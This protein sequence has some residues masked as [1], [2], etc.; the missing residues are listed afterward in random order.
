MKFKIKK[1]YLLESLNDVS[2]AM[3]SK[4][5]IP[6]LAGVKFEVKKDGI[7]LTCSDDDITIQSFIDKKKIETIDDDG[8]VVIPGK[9]ILDIVRKIPNEFIEIETDGL[10]IVIS[11]P[12]SVY[13]L[14]GMDA[15]DYPDK[16]LELTKSPIII[17]KKVIKN[18]INQTSFAISTQESRPI[19]TGINISIKENKLDAI[20]TDSYRLS[21]KIVI[22]KNAIDNEVNIVVPGRNLIELNKILNE[23]DEDIE[24]HIFSNKILFK[25]DHILFQSR[26]LNGTYPNVSNLI[27]EKFDLK[28]TINTEDLYN[29]IDRASIFGEK[30]KNVVHFEANKKEAVISSNSQELGKVEEKINIENEDN[31]NIKVSFNSKYMMDALRA[32]Q[33]NKITLLL[34]NEIKPIILRDQSS[35]TL[36]ELILPIKTY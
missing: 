1:E 16:S 28:I 6:V 5:L 7:Y 11:T 3:S 31:K 22:L 8:S 25:F 27:P 35:D 29:A 36:I 26:V 9:Y 4:N 14:N 18:I 15:K 19:L 33:C 23:E 12:S 13:N 21:K 17:N 30:E 24:M 2:K 34:Q 10:K 32:L 20:A